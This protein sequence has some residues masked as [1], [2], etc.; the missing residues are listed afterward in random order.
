VFEEGAG[1]RFRLFKQVSIGVR[2]WQD[3]VPPHLTSSVQEHP[4][5]VNS[6]VPPLVIDEMLFEL[7]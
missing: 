5:L 2:K 3:M 6:Q 4:G 7:S 1:F